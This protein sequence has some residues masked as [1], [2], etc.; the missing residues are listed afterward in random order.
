LFL[1]MQLISDAKCFIRLILFEGR[2]VNPA[3][4]ASSGRVTL[5]GNC[6]ELSPFTD[7]CFCLLCM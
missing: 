3:D 4:Y 5:Q 2:A 1:I 6:S 7:D